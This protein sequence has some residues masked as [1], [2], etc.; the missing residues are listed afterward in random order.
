[1]VDVCDDASRIAAACIAIRSLICFSTADCQ[2]PPSY[3]CCYRRP[4]KCGARSLTRIVCM[5]LTHHRVALIAG[6]GQFQSLHFLKSIQ[7]RRVFSSSSVLS[8]I[9][10]HAFSFFFY[11]YSL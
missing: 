9:Y 2:L 4:T 8:T 5:L 11:I 1:M 10:T 3:V 6:N 7:T